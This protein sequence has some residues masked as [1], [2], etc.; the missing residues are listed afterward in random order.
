MPNLYITLADLR[1]N[2]PDALRSTNTTY[3][4]AF[5]RLAHAIS[6]WIDDYCERVFYPVS[7]IRYF[8]GGGGQD[9]WPGDLIS[10]SEVAISEDNGLTYTALASTDYMLMGGNDYGP[11]G[12]YNRIRLDIN[13]DQVTW[14]TGQKAIR[15]TAVWGWHDDRAGAFEDSTDEVENNPLSDSGT[16]LTVNDIDGI[17]L[18]GVTPRF[19]EGALLRIGSEYLEVV[20]TG[21]SEAL[22]VVRGRNGTTAAAHLQNVQIDLW[23]PPA[24]VKQAALIQAIH[25]FKRAQAGYTDAEARPDL[26]RLM[27][28]KSLD[29]EA[30]ALLESVQ[31]IKV[32]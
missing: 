8:P 20:D 17:D 16:T 23:R 27:H 13:G 3:D 10:V 30:L 29:A 5:L 12:S 4:Q 14:P 9:L 2:A 15:I 19:S 25:Q 22:T 1:N 26:G 6:R 31:R 18:W 7:E 21:A 32:G 11:R 28:I 24:V